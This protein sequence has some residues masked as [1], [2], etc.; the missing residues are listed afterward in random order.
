MYIYRAYFIFRFYY[1]NNKITVAY[2]K[3]ITKDISFNYTIFEETQHNQLHLN[4][5]LICG[6]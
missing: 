2:I 3:V 4:Y 6:N 5:A 1:T